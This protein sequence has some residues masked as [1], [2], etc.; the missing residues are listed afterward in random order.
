VL[1]LGLGI[2]FQAQYWQL[3]P[4]WYHLPFLAL[5]LPGNVYGAWMFDASRRR[6]NALA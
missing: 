6:V 2:F 4:L 5:L 3:M 1:Q